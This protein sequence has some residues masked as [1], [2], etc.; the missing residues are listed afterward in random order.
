MY[1]LL[2]HI[3]LNCRIPTDEAMQQPDGTFLGC[4]ISV[5]PL[6]QLIRTGIEHYPVRI[7][8]LPRRRRKAEFEVW[9]LAGVIHQPLG[10][11]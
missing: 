3:Q 8:L 9:L 10:R 7:E 2:S 5:S 1:A 4:G 11:Q 6:S